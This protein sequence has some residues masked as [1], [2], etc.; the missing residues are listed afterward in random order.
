ME[1]R[2]LPGAPTGRGRT[3][4]EGLM[5]LASLKHT[6]TSW[7]RTESR[8]LSANPDAIF[9]VVGNLKQ[10][11]QWMKSFDGF[12]VHDDQ[13]GVGSTVDLLPPGRLLGALH[14]ETAPS[15]SITRRN[16]AQRLVEFT[17]PQPGGSLALRWA[18]EAVQGGARLHFTV[19]LTGPGTTAFKHTVANPLFDDFDISCARLYRLIPHQ[20][21][22]RVRRHVVIAGG[23]GYLGR[24]LTA[25]LVCRGNS[26]VVLTRTQ[27]PDFPAAQFL[28]DGKHQ[29]PWRAAFLRENYPVSLVNLAGELVDQRNTPASLDRLRSSRVDSTR[30][31][32]DA[33]ARLG[34]PVQTWVQ[35]STTAIFGDAGETRLTESSALPTDSAAL[36]EMTGVARPWEEAFA[37][38]PVRAEHNYVLRTSLVFGEQAPLLRRLLLLVR[39]GLGG[40]VGTGAQ[41]VSWIALADWLK[42]VRQLLGIE[43]ERPAEGIVHAAAP[44]PVRNE[45]MMRA[46]RAK[47]SM[48]GIGAPARLVQAGANLLGSNPRMALTGRHVTSSVLEELGF[49]FDEPTF[50]QMLQRLP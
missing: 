47:Y 40:P 43:G 23:R 31:L 8:F 37:Q 27:E 39:S 22:Y 11:G 16:Q 50:D 44:H 42:L 3:E 34:V 13:R 24:R 21:R 19:E 46:L 2:S 30:A 32:A 41:W 45:E 48:P 49:Q 5:T 38:A 25:D 14:R 36:P 1:T 12:L 28:W 10:T 7:Q 20:G 18:V 35:S 4:P 6:L 9:A 15:G 29:G 26:V 17:Q 33:V